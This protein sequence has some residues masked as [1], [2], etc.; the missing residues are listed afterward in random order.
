MPTTDILGPTSNAAVGTGIGDGISYGAWG[1]PQR[2]HSGSSFSSATF[3]VTPNKGTVWKS[4][5]DDEIPLD[6]TIIGVELM[7]GTDFDGSGNSRIANAGSTGG[8][9]SM[10][11]QM[12][13]YNGS[14]YSAPLAF[15]STPSGGSLN[16]DSTELTLTGANKSYV[17]NS[18]GDDLM[19]G[20]ADSLSGISWDPNNQDDF[21]FAITTIAE[22]GSAVAVVLRGVGLRVTYEEA[23]GFGH[24]T[25][26]VAAAS[27]AKVNTLATANIEKI[28]TVD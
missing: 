16:G 28:N 8:T 23:S 6:A 4:I 9:S 15:K 27:I 17:N 1:Q 14:A 11:Y 3:A 24:K 13:L 22:S 2:I 20:A 12:Y 19:A 5:F 18:A 26:T 21:G 25:I 10:T 7:G